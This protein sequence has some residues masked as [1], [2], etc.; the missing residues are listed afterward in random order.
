MPKVKIF[1][2]Y[3]DNILICP[4][5]MEALHEYDYIYLIDS[6]VEDRIKAL[7]FKNVKAIFP[8]AVCEDYLS[9]IEKSDTRSY[10]YKYEL[11][12]IGSI[13]PYRNYLLN[14]L[15]KFKIKIWGGGTWG[16]EFPKKIALLDQHIG[17]RAWGE[18]KKN[19]F[20]NTKININT[21]QPIELINGV[22]SRLF[23]IAASRSFQLC[24]YSNDL[25]KVFN[26]E[27]EIIS[28]KSKEELIDKIK[29]YLSRDVLREEIAKRSYE[30]F[31]KDHTAEKRIMSILNDF[32]K[33]N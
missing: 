4:T 25:E 18:Q 1:N 10:T 5:A 17:K 24:Q 2:Y 29:Y 9:P 23:Q 6:Y 20:K 14:N 16:I 28:F 31:L 12:L 19:I 15:G 32:N 3:L 26:I 33:V 7:G 21:I 30:R 11:S 8:F 22:N 27:N 13:Y